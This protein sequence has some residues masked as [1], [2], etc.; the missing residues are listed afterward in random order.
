MLLKNTHYKY[1]EIQKL[2]SSNSSFKLNEKSINDIK[3]S[4]NFLIEN[5]KRKKRWCHFDRRDKYIPKCS[6]ECNIKK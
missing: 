5:Q 3:D 2:F 1:D 4:Y 6:K